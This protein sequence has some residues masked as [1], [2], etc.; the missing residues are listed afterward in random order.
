MGVKRK[1]ICCGKTYDY[2]PNCDKGNNKLWMVTFDTEL[3]KELFNEV[4]LY[5]VKR[6]SKEDVQAFVARKGITNFSAFEEP[7]RKV[8][9]ETKF[10]RAD[11]RISV[12]APDES[13]AVNDEKET[14]S[15][16]WHKKKKKKHGYSF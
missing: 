7:I 5:N 4:S 1:C 16:P 2:C 6:A 13:A 14:F 15:I 12:P 11:R 3:C 9:E 8:L 10:D